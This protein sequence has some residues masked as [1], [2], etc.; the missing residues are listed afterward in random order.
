[1]V[2]AFF[3]FKSVQLSSKSERETLK[4][5][6]SFFFNWTVYFLFNREAI[7]FLFNGES[8]YFYIWKFG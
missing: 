6:F 4:I 5:L 8:A 2:D 3:E 7:Y 1:M